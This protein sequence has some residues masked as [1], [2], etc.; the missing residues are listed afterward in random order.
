MS[1]I[2]AVIVALLLVSLLYVGA[3]AMGGLIAD[4]AFYS[5]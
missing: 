2:K 4:I 5:G 3:K 1:K